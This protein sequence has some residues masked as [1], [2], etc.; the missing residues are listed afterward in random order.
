MKIKNKK[1][2]AVLCAVSM[3]T[4]IPSLAEE[5]TSA[6]IA[7]ANFENLITGDGAPQYGE[8]YIYHQE[9]IDK[10][11]DAWK[12]EN[13]VP[14]RYVNNGASYK[15]NVAQNIMIPEGDLY[16]NQYDSEG[17]LLH[18]EKDNQ[19]VDRGIWSDYGENYSKLSRK[20][21]R[22]TK[23]EGNTIYPG[24]LEGFSAVTEKHQYLAALTQRN[25]GKLV[26]DLQVIDEPGNDN[27]D[28]LCMNP[29]TDKWSMF[30]KSNIDLTGT[31]LAEARI[32][33]KD[34]KTEEVSDSR[35]TINIIKNATFDKISDTYDWHLVNGVDV[36][37]N[38]L[39]GANAAGYD[40][41]T[42]NWDQKVYL[43]SP[44]SGVYVCDYDEG[45]WY[46][47]KYYLDLS[48]AEHPK[49]IVII[50]NSNGEQIGYKE[51]EIILNENNSK[52]HFRIK[53]NKTEYSMLNFDG[54]SNTDSYS[55]M[56]TFDRGYYADITPCIYLD[57]VSFKKNV[58]PDVKKLSL[59]IDETVTIN[60]LTDKFYGSV[61]APWED[62]PTTNESPLTQTGIR[63]YFY[64]DGTLNDKLLADISDYPIKHIRYGGTLLKWREMLGAFSERKPYEY[65]IT[66][67]L[68]KT[69]TAKYS[70]FDCVKFYNALNAD[71]AYTYVVNIAEDPAEV[72]KMVEC[73]IGEGDTDGDGTDMTEIRKSEGIEAPINVEV[74]EL[75]NE[76]DSEGEGGWTV[77]NYIAKCKE[78][79]PAIRAVDPDAVIAVHE[80]TSQMGYDSQYEKN[81]YWHKQV[82]SELGN[83]INYLVMHEYYSSDNMITCLE[84]HVQRIENDIKEVTGSDKVKIYMSEHANGKNVYEFG[85]NAW[86]SEIRYQVSSLGGVI[87]DAEA[88]NRMSN[89][90]LLERANSFFS[91]N[92]GAWA[93]TY[94]DKD[95]NKTYKTLMYDLLKLYTENGVGDVVKSEFDGYNLLEN[96]AHSAMAVRNGDELNVFITNRSAAGL[97]IN[98]QTNEAYYI[99]S[100]T[101]ISGDSLND[102][103]SLLHNDENYKMTEYSE[104]KFDSPSNSI[105]IDPLSVTM[106]TLVNES[107]IN[108]MF[109]ADVKTSAAGKPVYTVSANMGKEFAGKDISASLVKDGVTIDTINKK[110]DASGKAAFDFE[111]NVSGD[112]V[113]A[114]IR[115]GTSVRTVTFPDVMTFENLI[116]G[117][118][119]PQY[120]EYYIYHQEWIDKQNDAWKAENDVP[121]RYVNNG[122]S[123]KGNVAQNIMI[124]EGDLYEN[125]YDSEGT[126]LHPEKDNQAVDRGIWS[127]Y[128]ENYSKLSRKLKRYTK[129]EGN[130]IYP[131]GLEGFSAVTEKHQY[132]AALTQRNTGKLVNDLQVIDE[133]GNDNNDVLCMNP[134]TD[135]WSMFGKSNIDLTGTTLAEARIY[136]KDIKTEEVSDSR[137]T[138]NIIKN[139]TFD[140][141]SDTY[142]WHLVNGV[143]VW[144]NG[145]NG[146]NAAGYDAVTFNWDQKVYLGSPES[147]VYV[148]DYDE[149][150]WYDVKYYLDLSD[151]EHPKNI[152]IIYNSNGEQIGYKEAEIILNEN[153]SKPHFRIKENKTEYSMLNFDGFS[154]TDSYS[155][156]Y[157]F[158]RGYYTD[159][160]PCVYLDDVSFRK[161]V[162]PEE[163][164]GRIN[165]A[166]EKN[167]SGMLTSAIIENT[168]ET[169]LAGTAIVAVYN[170][171]DSLAKM[172]IDRNVNVATNAQHQMTI[173]AE[174]YALAAGQK[175]KA[176]VWDNLASLLPVT[177]VFNLK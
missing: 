103:H 137:L 128:G 111:S 7:E 122:A 86:D 23:E 25:T 57:D 135:K 10:Q 131:G 139:A 58:V 43:G 14:R 123:Y 156:M 107:D 138:I 125:Q 71:T 1:I 173:S 154:N 52:P 94:Y 36:W 72:K 146:A 9:W 34:I 69:L 13:D 100:K 144:N 140:K 151:A 130:T 157:T 114:E 38:G 124:P 48:D 70:F 160:T 75:G 40:A 109:S 121:R 61:A 96:G 177:K 159:I 155:I 37:N 93:S 82:L 171:D 133:P 79:I 62:D 150:Q 149:G 127:D 87:D 2:L 64:P 29:F 4:P 39:N 163:D 19:A 46:D 126:L 30:G 153:N 11:N 158:D 145:L 85:D 90:P 98:L 33:T 129:E 63:G 148:C 31:T 76:S 60:T 89:Y 42:F 16:E 161:N 162:L 84:K 91:I 141:I 17:T 117:D 80:K 20:L 32:Y 164:T 106:L 77:D 47:V 22:Y 65:Q 5:Q 59:N 55:I 74:W 112:G 108:K 81:S 113:Y 168:T 120:G 152:V 26:N 41:V 88:F 116:T 92:T 143:D 172:F 24:G 68:T 167:E 6:N 119:A 54:F 3:L 132:L 175:V 51:A 142:D 50:Y 105:T 35:L 104:Y 21:K 8:Y 83:D 95:N 134:F 165:I 18:P 12:A 73:Y 53:E 136:T 28:V 99:K 110:A 166:A 101:V 147:G 66:D 118:G 170:A 67:T 176:F 97:D 27:N 115:F 44:E 78:L 49:N 174:G 45:Q 169:A 102:Y 15:G 56:Y